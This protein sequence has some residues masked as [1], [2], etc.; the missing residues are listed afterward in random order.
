MVRTKSNSS[1]TNWSRHVV[2][3]VLSMAISTALVGLPLTAAMAADGDLVWAVNAAEGTRIERGSS[4]APL[5]DGTMLVTGA[6]GD[7]VFP[8]GFDYTATFGPG[9]PNETTL[10]SVN[11]FDMFVAKYDQ[12]GLLV[13][14]T[15]AGGDGVDDGV[16]IVALADGSSLV[17]GYFQN[18][19]TF[20]AG[21][22]NQ[23]SLTTLGTIGLFLAKYNPDGT[24]AWAVDAGGGAGTWT[25]GYAVAA[26]SDGSALLT[27]NFSAGTVTFGA[28]ETNETVLTPVGGANI[29]VGHERRRRR[30]AWLRHRRGCRRQRAGRRI[31]QRH[32]DVR[33]RR[34]ERDLPDRSR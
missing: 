3:T 20:G 2:I 6:Y 14:A 32:G 33:C 5:P 10:P 34:D 28:G 4:I 12:N 30:F 27:G 25:A 19:A 21:E 1:E 15:S 31:F 7:A 24:L 22:S 26:L 29:F 23:T 9:D 17:T 16:G 11:L 18:I 8:P 13:W